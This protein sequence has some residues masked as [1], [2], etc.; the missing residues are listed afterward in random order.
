MAVGCRC[1]KCCQWN[2]RAIM[3]PVGSVG[4]RNVFLI[5]C[6]SLF[7]V[8]SVPDVY[9]DSSPLMLVSQHNAF[10][11]TWR[12]QFLRQVQLKLPNEGDVRWQMQ[13][14]S[15]SCLPVVRAS[16]SCR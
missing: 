7:L 5:D 10:C 6:L 15:A 11:A 16:A 4:K 9:L 12:L 1:G 14:C 3:Q 13:R 2:F 8:H